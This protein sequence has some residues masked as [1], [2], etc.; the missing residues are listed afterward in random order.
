VPIYKSR[1]YKRQLVNRSVV[2]LT[3]LSSSIAVN[4]DP[5]VIL[6]VKGIND[7]SDQSSNLPLELE[8]M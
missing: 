3:I 2:V 7:Q 8:V 4:K 5:P 1:R 6:T